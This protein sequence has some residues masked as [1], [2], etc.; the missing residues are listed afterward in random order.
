MDPKIR[1]KSIYQAQVAVCRFFWIALFRSSS[2]KTAVC[3]FPFFRLPLPVFVAETSFA[4]SVDFRVPLG[5]IAVCRLVW[6][7]EEA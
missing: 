3:R 2:R 4:A 7:V 5:W 1:C 6:T